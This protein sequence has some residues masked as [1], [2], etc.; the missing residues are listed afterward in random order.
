MARLPRRR[1]NFDPMEFIYL[2]ILATL[3][4]R[5]PAD[6]Q[7]P[8]AVDP[9]SV[10]NAASRMPSS[11]AGGA[12][13]RGARFSLSG[14]RLGPQREVKG[15]ESSP[16]L[17]L[18]GVSVHIVQGQKDIPAGILFASAGRIDGLIP[19]S[20]PLGPVQ[21]TVI[22]NGLRSE[23]Y[24]IMLVDASFG[25]YT[26]DT[27]PE[28]LPQARLPLSATPGET[29]AAWGTGLGEAPPEV[30]V[31]G[32]PVPVRSA[33]E[34][35]CCQGVVRIEFQIP[36]SA[37]LGCSVPIQ[38]RVGNRPSN[39]IAISIHPA[40]RPCSGQIEWL[41]KT[42]Q[43]ATRAG[44]IALARISLG[45]ET[46]AKV[47]SSQ[48]DYAVA[49]FGN[50]RAGQRPFPP[51][52]PFGACTVTSVRINL[53]EVLS[54]ARSPSAWTGIPTPL[55]GNLGLDAGASISVSGPAGVKVLGREGRQRD[56]YSALLGGA[57][58]F[59]QVPRTRLY[60]APDF[61]YNVSSSGGKDIG[62]FTA[63]VV[64]QRVIEWKNRAR[65]AEVRR[66]AGVTLEWK[67]AR[68][69]DAVLIA[70]A[71][72][73]HVTGDSSV[74]VCL[75]HARDRRFTIPPISLGNLPVTG[76]DDLEPS[77]LLLS[78]LPLL[79]PVAIQA[80]GLDAAFAAFLSLNARLVKYR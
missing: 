26:V 64:A 66:S 5:V 30:F 80:Q 7:I 45:R 58:P 49:T 79:P 46:A 34:K 12:L 23:P 39:V 70:A 77:V 67:E 68:A 1:Y 6:A 71:S 11:L 54:Q 56:A 28:E 18:D 75:A 13:A 10:V 35:T 43:H 27:A 74:C 76:N 22:Y 73:D 21:L 17:D 48:F 36:A 42:V 47:G 41:D 2:A 44:F 33:D 8:P 51:L 31:A 50:Q 63:R 72:A 69:D 14:V 78:E 24:P 32:R 4:L 62:P 15:D 57:V 29:V 59:S 16:P 53:R 60:F 61:V 9:G 37:P 3:L 40:G 38:A 19:R 25:F 65:L 55:P 20:A 52:P